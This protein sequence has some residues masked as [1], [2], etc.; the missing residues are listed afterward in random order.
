MFAWK[1]KEFLHLQLQQQQFAFSRWFYGKA[2]G[3]LWKATG[4]LG[5][6]FSYNLFYGWSFGGFYWKTNKGMR[7]PYR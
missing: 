4:V 6:N 5:V 7:Y 3:V 1:G 2:K